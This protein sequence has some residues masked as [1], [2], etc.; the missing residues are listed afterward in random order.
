MS[1]IA[2]FL[3]HLQPERFV[4]GGAP[5]PPLFSRITWV[6]GLIT[7]AGATI[8]PLHRLSTQEL[9]AQT[10]PSAV[11]TRREREREREGRLTDFILLQLL[12]NGRACKV[13]SVKSAKC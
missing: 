8:E 9:S 12:S 6:P 13:L 4:S 11:P 5:L 1:A 7:L 3:D 2:F 10:Q